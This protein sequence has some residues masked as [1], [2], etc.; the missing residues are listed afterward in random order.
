[1]VVD[2]FNEVTDQEAPQLMANTIKALSDDGVN[3]TVV[4][5]GVARNV[6]DLVTGHESIS[7]CCEEVPMPRMNKD[8]LKEVIERRINHLGMQIEG[9]A[10]WKIINLSKGLPSFVHGLGKYSCYS[11]IDR[12]KRRVTES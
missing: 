11:A 6:T 2:E 4:V 10:K 8:E 5:V 3:A 7:R 1:M 9:N 12:R